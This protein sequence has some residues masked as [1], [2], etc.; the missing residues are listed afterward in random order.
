MSINANLPYWR[1]YVQKAFLSGPPTPSVVECVV[2]AVTSLKGQVPLFHIQTTC[3]AVRWRVPLNYLCADPTAQIRDLEQT[4][5][6]NCESEHISVTLFDWLKNS[7]VLARIAG[8]T[9]AGKYLFTLDWA[10][11]DW[12]TEATDTREHKC[13]HV[14]ETFEGNFLCVPTNAILFHTEGFVDKLE[15]PT[16]WTW[17]EQDWHVHQKITDNYHYETK[18]DD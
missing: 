14:I 2:F 8:K 9:Y 10:D 7:R 5:Y 13:G 3:G 12:K 6:W 16:D 17:H 11:K 4:Y 15:W 1:C 18:K